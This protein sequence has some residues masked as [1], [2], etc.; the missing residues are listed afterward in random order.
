LNESLEDQWQTLRRLRSEVTTQ[1]EPMRREKIVG[2][3]LEADVVVALHNEFAPA[4]I[5]HIDLGELFITSSARCIYIGD[6]ATDA[7]NGSF[8]ATEGVVGATPISVVRTTNH[9]CGRCWRHLPEVTEDG[10]LCGR[11]EDVLNG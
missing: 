1:I 3:S 10:A 2:S 11:C 5:A 6:L 8:A 7:A 9:K 4:S